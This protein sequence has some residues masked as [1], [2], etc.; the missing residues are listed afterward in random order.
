MATHT[1]PSRITGSD[2]SAP[3]AAAIAAPISAASITDI[4]ARSVSWKAAKP[5]MAA[6]VPW[7]SEI[8]PAIPVITV[9]LVLLLQAEQLTWGLS[10]FGVALVAL[11]TLQSLFV[12]AI[13]CLLWRP[14]LSV[15]RVRDRENVLAV[16]LDASSSMAYG[17]QDRSRLQQAVQSLQGEPLAALQ[18]VFVLLRARAEGDE[19]RSC[20]NNPTGDLPDQIVA[21]LTDESRDDREHRPIGIFRKPKTPQ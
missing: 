15:E 14:V 6:K 21:F 2:S 11:G 1:P 4:P 7:H 12:A 17:D 10:L 20:F 18:K 3:A 13:L 5:P 19:E 8:S 16:A 9:A